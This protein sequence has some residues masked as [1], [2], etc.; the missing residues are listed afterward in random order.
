MTSEETLRI[1][2]LSNS[3]DQEIL[4]YATEIFLVLFAARLFILGRKL[5]AT[6]SVLCIPILFLVPPSGSSYLALLAIPAIVLVNKQL[7]LLRNLMMGLVFALLALETTTVSYW[8][9]YPFFRLD[10]VSNVAFLE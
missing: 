1:V 2:L 6:I 8:I 3:A 10:A 9:C 7:H 5:E 4:V